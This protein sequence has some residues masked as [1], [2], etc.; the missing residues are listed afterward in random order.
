MF[1][2]EYFPGT[3]LLAN[4]KGTKSG[5]SNVVLDQAGRNPLRRIATAQ[6]MVLVDGKRV[7]AFYEDAFLGYAESERSGT[8]A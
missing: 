1:F 3:G 7:S 5:I 6:I 8:G 4:F 2:F